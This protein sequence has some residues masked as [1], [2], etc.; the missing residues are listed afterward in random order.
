VTASPPRATLCLLVTYAAVAVLAALQVV[1]LDVPAGRTWLGA[2]PYLAGGGVVAAGA[3]WRADV[4][5]HVGWRWLTAAGVA[6]VALG[7]WAVV[8]FVRALPAGAGD[9]SGFYRVK[10][11]VTTPLGDHNTAAGVLLVGVVAAVVLAHRD[12]RWWVGV[13]VTVLGLVAC[14]SRGASLVLLVAGVAGLVAGVRRRVTVAVLA[15]GAVATVATLALAAG[16]GAAPPPGAAVPDGPVGTS[17]VGRLDLAVLG[18]ELTAAH[19]VLG[20]GLGGFEDAA[21]GLPPPNDHAH[22]ALAHAGAEG[23]LPLVAVVAT[24]WVVLAVRGLRSAPGWRRDVAL[25]AG[26]ALLAH[27]QIDVLTG[28]VGPEL[29]LGLLLVL[30]GGGGLRRQG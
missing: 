10:V 23:G 7:T 3:A 20:V 12:R 8:A 29:T 11:L 30:A 27:A 4:D 5:D 15:A 6:A 22:D 13:V 2:L 1:A 16:L 28:R 9:P 24:L 21:G 19:P 25:L 14:L 26:G 18:F 17:V